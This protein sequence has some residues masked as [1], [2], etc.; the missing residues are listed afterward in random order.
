MLPA[1]LLSEGGPGLTTRFTVGA[2][3][4]YPK[5]RIGGSDHWV[6]VGNVT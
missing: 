4:H 2:Y 1:S 3:D 5:V 6:M